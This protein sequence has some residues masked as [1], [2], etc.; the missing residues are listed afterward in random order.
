MKN[1]KNYASMTVIFHA[2]GYNELLWI[3]FSNSSLEKCICLTINCWNKNTLNTVKTVFEQRTIYFWITSSNMSSGPLGPC[4]T[5]YFFIIVSLKSFCLWKNT[6]ISLHISLHIMHYF[7][8]PWSNLLFL[9][10]CHKTPFTKTYPNLN[11]NR[12]CC[13]EPK[14]ISLLRS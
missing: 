4:F 13:N 1:N 2:M 7:F 3:H 11:P 8:W 9:L 10:L 14:T 6:I 5:F 12:I